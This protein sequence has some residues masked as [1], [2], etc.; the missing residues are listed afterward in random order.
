MHSF[1]LDKQIYFKLQGE[2]YIPMNSAPRLHHYSIN[3]FKSKEKGM[4]E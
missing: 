3:E 2:P 4:D 1:C